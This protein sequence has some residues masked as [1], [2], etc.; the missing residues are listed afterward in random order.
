VSV[1]DMPFLKICH[2]ATSN[3]KGKFKFATYEHQIGI[4]FNSNLY[5]MAK[6]IKK[7][8]GRLKKSLFNCRFATIKTKHIGEYKVC[9]QSGNVLT[10]P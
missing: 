1:L 7:K 9:I 6:K 3:E 4:I 5:S 10:S 2:Y 8:K